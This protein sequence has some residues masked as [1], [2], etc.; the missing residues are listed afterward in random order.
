MARGDLLKKL[1]LAYKQGEDS[2]IK[3]VYME[4][5]NEERNKNHH[6]LANQLQRILDDE[7]YGFN[8]LR[9]FNAYSSVPKD[10]NGTPLVDIKRPRRHFE[11][12]I[13]SQDVY[14]VITEVIEEYWRVDLIRAYNLK[15]KTKLLFYGPPGCGKSLCAEALAAEL[16][17]PILYCRLDS[18]I[19]SYLGDTS[20]NIRKVFDFASKSTWVM[21]FDEFDAI[22][23]SRNDFN[24]HGELKRVVNSFLQIIDNFEGQSLIIACTNH[25]HLLDRAIWRR[26]DDVIYFGKPNQ[27]DI[28]NLIRIKTKTFRWGN[29]DINELS[30]KMIGMSHYEVERICHESIKKC[31]L[32]GLDSLTTDIIEQQYDRELKRIR[33]MGEGNN[34]KFTT[35]EDRN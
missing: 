34:E 7:G 5:I 27:E 11:D 24:E 19:S 9:D 4:I 29:V 6:V 2:K 33:A 18:L 15:P 16:G 12:V 22:G 23:K 3:Q 26:F 25:E 20:T 17:L 21:L 10:D 14:R 35:S 30:R 8:S 32:N 28:S 31:I 1:F 13:L